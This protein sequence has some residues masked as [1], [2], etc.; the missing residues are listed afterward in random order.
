MES[1]SGRH[2]PEVT[3]H[4]NPLYRDLVSAG[5]RRMQAESDA[6]ARYDNN[7]LKGQAREIFVSSLLR[8]FLAPSAGLCSGIAI[9]S[10]GAHSRQLD[11]I[12]FDR[13]VIAPSMLRETDGVIPVES[14]LA[15]VEIKSTLSRQELVSTVENARSVKLLRHRPEEIEQGSPVKHSPL[16]YV[17]AFRSDLSG[18]SELVRLQDVVTASNV[19]Q[20]QIRVPIGGLCVPQVGFFHCTNAGASPPAFDECAPQPD[21]SEVLRFM[22][23]VVDNTDALASERRPIVLRH[24]LFDDDPGGQWATT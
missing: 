11:L 9:D 7:V 24:Y 22:V 4:L 3:T 17:F 6:A 8:P 16:C 10:F 13:R 20:R 12:I 14:V 19:N 21:L 23:H 5:I 1:P 15:T 2:S 18:S